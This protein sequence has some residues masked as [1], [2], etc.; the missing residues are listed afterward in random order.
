MTLTVKDSPV[1]SAL[2]K[3]SSSAQNSENTSNSSPRSNPV[4][5]EV[6]VVLRSLPGEQA[7]AS[8]ATR[9][10]GRTVI[11][12]DN[13][14][15]LRISKQ[16]PPGQKVI[17]SNQQGRDVVCRVM[18]GRNLPNKGYIEIE[19]IEQIDDFWRIHQTPMP[20]SAP[21]LASSAPVEVA[22][23]TMPVEL[24]FATTSLASTVAPEQAAFARDTKYSS[25]SAPTFEDVAELMHMAPRIG[26]VQE[27]WEKKQDKGIEATASTPKGRDEFSGG[28][29]GTGKLVSSTSSRKVTPLISELPSEKPAIPPARETAS[30]SA[31]NSFQPDVLA[32]KGVLASPYSV[33]ASATS[34][35]RK[36][37]PLIL[38]GAALVLVGFGA[39]FF[40]MHRGTASK[41]PPVAVVSESPALPAPASP[42]ASTALDPDSQSS[43]NQLP[44]ETQVLSQAPTQTVPPISTP[45]PVVAE[46]SAPSIS[47]SRTT[48][49]P[50][51]TPEVTKPDVTQSH[52]PTISNLRM[53]SPAVPNQSPM[54]LA[55][56][57]SLSAT[58]LAP[59]TVVA[60]GG[61]IP[62]VMGAQPAPPAGPAPTPRAKTV[63]EPQ[64]I[65]STHAIYPP[66]AKQSNVQGKVVVTASVDAKGD[67]V[68]V[69]AVSGPPFLRQAAMDAVKQWKYSPALID[70]RPA[71]AQV[72]VT[73]EFR[74]S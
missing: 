56:G 38:G 11:V 7:N 22:Q 53:K 66:F 70:G 9:E 65:S 69:T 31:R 25:G 44:P 23:Q 52:R 36:P 73:L 27:N 45:A 24:P 30:A 42:V 10:E 16:L 63:Q 18:G 61:Q 1:D 54:K 51:R 39:G 20:V 15:V 26:T 13:G 71:S 49:P 32:G 46:S 50:A 35:S 34:E 74:L 48:R 57:L 47:D 21:S 41:A 5:L 37:M 62:S 58:D 55:D 19:F 60:G 28:V 59:T 6:P 29:P 33:A 40:M 8:G 3:P 12:F 2:G 72:T 14:A 43:I 17:L 64:L 4:C 67:V 68:A